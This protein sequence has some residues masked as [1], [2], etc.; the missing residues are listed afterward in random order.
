M[1]EYG[2]RRP[3]FGFV[4]QFSLAFCTRTATAG[5]AD[6]EGPCEAAMAHPGLRALIKPPCDL[7]VRVRENA[8]SG[9]A[10]TRH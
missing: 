8:T 9:G 6:G 1:A 5:G 3:S 7:R 10:L 2:C 4:L